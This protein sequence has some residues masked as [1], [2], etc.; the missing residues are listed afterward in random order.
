MSKT[1]IK[2]KSPKNYMTRNEKQ[3]YEDMLL[4]RALRIVHT[5]KFIPVDEALARIRAGV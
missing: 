1:V 2:P 5:G 3:A 4:G